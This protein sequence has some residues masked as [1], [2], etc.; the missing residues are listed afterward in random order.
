MPT[1]GPPVVLFSLS[2]VNFLLDFLPSL[3]QHVYRPEARLPPAVWGC[4]L[5]E[6][7][8]AEFWICWTLLTD[9]KLP[10]AKLM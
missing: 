4:I 2:I 5:D 6:A 10:V 8:R 3:E 7:G 9:P 1:D